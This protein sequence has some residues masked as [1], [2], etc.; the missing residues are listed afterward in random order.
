M[1]F[2]TTKNPYEHFE[3]TSHMFVKLFTKKKEM[4]ETFHPSMLKEYNTV[5]NDMLSTAFDLLKLGIQSRVDEKCVYITI[6][7]TEYSILR[8]DMMKVINKNQWDELFP[9]DNVQII[10]AEIETEP[11]T[12]EEGGEDQEQAEH[13][14]VNPTVQNMQNPLMTFLQ[15]LYAPIMGMTNQNSSDAVNNMAVAIKSAFQPPEVDLVDEV[16]GIQ[17]KI[18]RL[19]KEKD[20]ALRKC[21]SYRQALESATADAEEAKAQHDEELENCTAGLKKEVEDLKNEAEKSKSR[22]ENAFKERDNLQKEVGR[23]NRLVEDGKNEVNS[24]K[25]KL[26]SQLSERDSKL[27]NIERE[28][29]ELK[30]KLEAAAKS[31]E[32]NLKSSVQKAKDEVSASLNKTIEERNRKISELES[33][34]KDAKNNDD[35]VS[36]YESK[37]KEKDK[38]LAELQ[39]KFDALSAEVDAG[40]KHQSE[41]QSKIESL[42][43]ENKSLEGLAYYDKKIGVGNNNAFNRDIQAVD[44]NNVSL[45]ITG[46]RNMKDINDRYGRQAGDKLI[47]IAAQEC[48]NEFGDHVYRVFGDE[49]AIITEGDFS[50]IL[51]KLQ[52]IKETLEAQQIFIVYGVSVGSKVADLKAMVTEAEHA[53]VAMKTNPTMGGAIS[54]TPQD[55]KEEAKPAEAE[56]EEV[57][58]SDVMAEYLST[59]N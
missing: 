12:E 24:V 40:K 33:S 51:S 2:E 34:L 14:T 21:Q 43:Q 28:K 1:D 16:G 25:N 41:L 46:V 22:A 3:R 47:Q 56:P 58:M 11:H 19:E 15:A 48:K 50:S 55:K 38:A 42:E 13:N 30:S 39:K 32:D 10:K 57:D 44:K 23:L 18:M 52:A 26:Q 29:N 20:D 49:F 59:E 9:M 31:A 5:K 36:E 27:S 6:D 54:A 45:V 7:D 35:L 17:K 8:S 53:M 37:L 4:E